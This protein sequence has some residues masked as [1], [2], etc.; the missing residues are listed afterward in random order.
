MKKKVIFVICLAIGFIISG[1]SKEISDKPVTTKKTETSNFK[2]DISK[3]VECED[4]TVEEVVEVNKSSSNKTKESSKTK[5]DSNQQ[6]N[7]VNNLSS[8]IPKKED[9]LIEVDEIQKE[10]IENKTDSNVEVEDVI[11]VEKEEKPT[12]EQKNYKIGNS[13]KLFDTEEQ[14]DLEAE[15]M[16]NNFSDPEKYISRYWIW[17][18]YDKW[19]IEYEY[20]NWE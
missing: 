5:I 15:S 18:T 8:S 6:K 19:T 14:A 9:E 17:S 20:T 12:E 1:C 4:E 3:K 10:P 2:E 7:K 16:F 11:E 13:G